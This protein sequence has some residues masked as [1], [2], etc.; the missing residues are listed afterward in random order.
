MYVLKVFLHSY[1]NYENVRRGYKLLIV[2]V[3]H[4][5]FILIFRQWKSCQDDSA[6]VVPVPLVICCIQTT[7]LKQWIFSCIAGNHGAPTGPLVS[8]FAPID[9][10]NNS[11][12]VMI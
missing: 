10:N 9:V 6:V 11:Y 7:V 4:E 2:F 5:C 3:D 1:Q 12:N 8:D